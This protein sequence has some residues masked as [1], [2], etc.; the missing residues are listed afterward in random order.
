MKNSDKGKV[1]DSIRLLPQQIEDALTQAKK[2]KLP[3]SYK[4]IN[5]VVVSGMGGSN[6]GARIIA[7]VFKDEARAP[8]LIEPGYQ[9]PAY[10]DRDTLYIIS[11]YSGNTEEPLST[12]AEAKARGAKIVGLTE[13]SVKNKLAAL[14]EKE[15]LPG[16]IFSPAQN[17][18]S[19][20]PR[21]GLGYSIFAL[22]ALLAEVGVIKIDRQEIT[23]II[24]ALEKN[25]LSFDIAARQIAKKIS[26]K[27]II[28]VGAEFLAG[29]LHALRNQFCETSKNFS[30]YLVVPDMNHYALEG[31]SN[32]AS[33]RKNQVY[34]FWQSD[35]YHPRVAKRLRLTEEIVR[36]NKISVLSIKLNGKTKLGQAAEMLQLGSWL[37][38]YLAIINQVDPIAIKSVDWFKKKLS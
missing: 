35:F 19:R 25:N 28:L 9:V 2:F 3:E 32:P 17:N 33:N 6:L 37:T 27:E 14:L 26:N 31:L 30:A 4:K 12:F 20:Q 16:F 13:A 24:S 7:A 5:R 21:L 15:S 36:K 22:L 18:P 34:V 8:I 10:V 11:S 29:S 1:A 38:F 23:R